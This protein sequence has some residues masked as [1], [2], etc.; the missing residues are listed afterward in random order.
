MLVS[1]TECVRGIG[2]RLADGLQ[3]DEFLRHSL[4]RIE[5]LP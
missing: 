4:E 2:I 1:I 5:A 3:E